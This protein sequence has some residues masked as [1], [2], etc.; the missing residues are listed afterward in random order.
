M[1]IESKKLFLPYN[2]IP[3]N[4]VSDRKIND[5][6]N[7][8]LRGQLLFLPNKDLKIKLAGDITRQ[9]PDGYG[10][11][12]AGIVENKLSKYRQFNEIIKDLG[13]E[14]PYKSAF[15]RKV[16]LDTRSRA[17]N[18]LGGISLNLGYKIGKGTLTSTSAWRYWG[19]GPVE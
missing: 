15:E 6:N 5:Q 4:E 3:Y 13:Y 1:L 19:L 7:L 18:E 11:E 2:Y 14:I 12:V 8:D 9:R 10:W 16:D 17:D